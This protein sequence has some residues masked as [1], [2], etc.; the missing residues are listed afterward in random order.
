MVITQFAAS[1]TLIIGT[2]TVYLQLNYMKGHELGFAL[3]QTLIVP[4]PDMEDSIY[5]QKFAVFKQR[6]KQYPEVSGIT[7]SSAIP[8]RKADWNAGGIRR[9][10]QREDEANQFRVIMMDADFIPSY[11][12]QV[13]AG[14]AFSEKLPNEFR[15]V[16]LN[17]AAAEILAPETLE[18]ETRAPAV[19]S[20]RRS[21]THAQTWRPDW[22]GRRWR[23]R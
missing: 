15:N 23:R 13:V 19:E 1:L 17:E 16:M 3:D 22:H 12:L 4:S 20:R 14:R 11:G 7:A 10:S 2:F 8:G 6:I 21:E 18:G 9:L 5:V